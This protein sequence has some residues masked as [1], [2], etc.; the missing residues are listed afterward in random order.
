MVPG[1]AAC[2]NAVSP[3][4]SPWAGIDK[5]NASERI[6]KDIFLVLEL[7]ISCIVWV[8]SWAHRFLQKN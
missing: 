8:K 1:Y 4:G 3:F 6:M 2:C 5:C 7:I